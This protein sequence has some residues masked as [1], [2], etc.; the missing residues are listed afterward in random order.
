MESSHELSAPKVLRDGQ[1]SKASKSAADRGVAVCGQVRNGKVTEL[2][3]FCDS[4]MSWRFRMPEKV[5]KK[6]KFADELS[7]SKTDANGLVT[8]YCKLAKGA[9]G[10]VK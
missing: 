4:A 1:T 10:L 8:V 5:A 3:A 6:T 2:T 7:L 9:T